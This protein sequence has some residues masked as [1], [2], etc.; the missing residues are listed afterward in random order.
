MAVSLLTFISG[1]ACSDHTAETSAATQ[2]RNELAETIK[3]TD[4][5]APLNDITKNWKAG[6]VVS[7]NDVKTAGINNCFKAEEISDEVFGRIKGKSFP[8]TCTVPRKDLRYVKVLHRNANGNIQL[9]ELICN[10]KISHLLISIFRKL[11]D[12]GYKIER[13]VLIDE[14]GADD[15]K[16]MAS[17]N[18]SCFNFRFVTG[19]K[20]V[21][22]HGQGLAIDIN[23]LYNPCIRKVNGKTIVEPVEGTPYATGRANK[24][25][26]YKIDQNDLAY[27]LFIK[28]GFT[29]G[30]AWKSLKDYQHFEYNK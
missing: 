4:E 10:K 2:E 29:W 30:G 27:K 23:P 19:S 6:N 8:S 3:K 16:S 21:S 11:Y 12:A 13:M 22:K 9:G 20:K 7:E 18:S 28:N 1:S 24:E 5:E 14:Y 25:I 26:P 15:Q 17:N